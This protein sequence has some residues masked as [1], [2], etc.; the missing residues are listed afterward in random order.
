MVAANCPILMMVVMVCT[1][2]DSLKKYL[3]FCS[4]ALNN[5]YAKTIAKVKSWK[6]QFNIKMRRLY[7][8]VFLVCSLVQGKPTKRFMPLRGGCSNANDA[9]FYPLAQ[10]IQEGFGQSGTRCSGGFC[11]NDQP[12]IQWEDP[13]KPSTHG[14]YCLLL[15]PHLLKKIRVYCCYPRPSVRPSVTWTPS[16]YL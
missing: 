10:A 14:M 15:Y 1:A 6:Q 5:Q 16:T 7:L 4:S 8:V 2:T 3:S 9:K 13:W 11:D 12:I